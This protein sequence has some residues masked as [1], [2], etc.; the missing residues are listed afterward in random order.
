MH[1]RDL[2]VLVGSAGDGNVVVCGIAFISSLLRDSRPIS[3]K[4]IP[5]TIRCSI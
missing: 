1:F 5:S 2:V 3:G 4:M